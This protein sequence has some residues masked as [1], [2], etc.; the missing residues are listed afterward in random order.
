MTYR[1]YIDLGTFFMSVIREV[2]EAVESHLGVQ[3][4]AQAVIKVLQGAVWGRY[5][6]GFGLTDR[7]A[8]ELGICQGDINAPNRSKNLMKL[9][10]AAISEM[11]EG[12]RF[13]GWEEGTVQVWFADDGSVMTDSWAWLQMAFDTAWML[14]RITGC[15]I[16]VKEDGSKT[17]WQVVNG[18][19]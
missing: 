12:F 8:M 6:T 2:A 15:E 17:A 18:C 7:V 13:C 10:Q 16:G 1:G 19:E 11:I 4:Q 5:E 14:S 3:P 9:K